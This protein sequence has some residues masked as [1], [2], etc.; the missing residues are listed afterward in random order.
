MWTQR[1]QLQAYQFLRRRL[2]SA[3]VVGDANHPVSPSRRLVIGCIVG[4]AVTLLTVAGFGI[5]GVLRPGSS[6]DWRKPGQVVLDSASGANYVLGKDGRLYPMANQASARLFAGS[7]TTVSVSPKSLATAPRGATLGIAGAPDSLPATMLGNRWTV[8]SQQPADRPTDTTPV[9]TALLGVAPSVRSLRTGLVVSD[10]GGHRYLLAN[11]HRY[12][13]ADDTIAVALSYDRVTPLPVSWSFV[14]VVPAGPDLGP[15]PVDGAGGQGPTLAGT[16]TRVGEVVQVAGQTGNLYLVESGGLAPID[17]LPAR[18]VLATPQNAA[19]YP[20]GNPTVK[21]VPAAAVAG[22]HRLDQAYPDRPV[23][24]PPAASPAGP[25]LAACLTLNGETGVVGA[26]WLSDHL[27]L[28]PGAKPVATGG[29]AGT[30]DRTADLVLVAPGTGLL[31]AEHQSGTAGAGTTYLVTDQGIRFPVAG[32]GALA[33]LGYK[34][35]QRKPVA[36]A[37]LALLPVGPALDPAAAARPEE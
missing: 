18:L 17:A 23:D 5:Y 13:L 2:V 32:G 6:Q 15:L 12:L 35:A 3:L 36:S 9:T 37:L 21:A 7:A 28:R 8:C 11:G 24:L 26:L 20:D 14:D 19:A 1:D 27:P 10:P 33:A 31:A 22:A 16:P 4:L 25:A 30:S 34:A 29:G